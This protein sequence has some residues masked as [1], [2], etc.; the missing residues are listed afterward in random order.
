MGLLDQVGEFMSG[1]ARGFIPG[2]LQQDP[3]KDLLDT[4]K[5]VQLANDVKSS[6]EKA[7]W[8]RKTRINA[9]A[10]SAA[11]MAGVQVD[12]AQKRSLLPPQ[13]T[14]A[15]P[16]GPMQPLPTDQAG[17]PSPGTPAVAPQMIPAAPV[18]VGGFEGSPAF[19]INPDAVRT[20]REVAAKAKDAQDILERQA[21]ARITAE[22]KA[23]SDKMAS[24]DRRYAADLAHQ[25]R[26]AAAGRTGVTAWTPEAIHQAAVQLVT[27]N[28]APSTGRDTLAKAQIY[29]EAARLDPTGNWAVRGA[30]FKTDVSD[31]AGLKKLQSQVTQAEG[32]ARSNLE[33]MRKASKGLPGVGMPLLDAPIRSI[34][35]AMG[36]Y[37]GDYGTNVTGFEAAR[38]VATSEV[39]KVI[40]QMSA[41]GVLSDHAQ[42][43]ARDLIKPGA[44][45]DQIERALQII[46]ADMDNRIKQISGEVSNVQGRLAGPVETGARK[47]R[48]LSVKVLP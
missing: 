29:N 33:I 17:P 4:I 18:H 26:A 21:A 39:A 15:I 31:L 30:E 5:A 44:T 28:T 45:A 16:E 11:Q 25:D 22:Q 23:A 6:Q 9:E 47:P 38:Q 37:A 27:S 19:D 32:T 24:D 2:Q 7:A 43:E 10:V 35:G 41:S 46:H 3:N 13:M 40:T 1:A 20:Q 12:M 36:D 48:V 34:A 8:E 42:A 14:A